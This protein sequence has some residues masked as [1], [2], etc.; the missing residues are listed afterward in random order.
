MSGHAVRLKI[1]LVIS[2]SGQ[3]VTRTLT[4]RVAPLG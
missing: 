2:S 1:Q 4:V 3:K